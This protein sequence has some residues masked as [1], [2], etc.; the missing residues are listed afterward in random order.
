MMLNPDLAKLLL[1]LCVGGLMLFHGVFKIL[2]GV[3]VYM[4]MLESK[5]LPGIMV[6]GVYI[7]EVLAPLLILIGYQVRIAALIVAFTMIM[8]IYLVYGF[9]IFALDSYGGWVIEHQLLYILPCLAL[10]FMGGG[11]YAFFKKEEKIKA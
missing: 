1:R 10:F 7:G 5:G 9:E 3:D 4:G 11:K 6:Y 8:A 2:H